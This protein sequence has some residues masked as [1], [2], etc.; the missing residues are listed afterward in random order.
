[1]T[2]QH[3]SQ[4]ILL[5][6]THGLELLYQRPLTGCRSEKL[7]STD[8]PQASGI[9]LPRT[10]PA[11]GWLIAAPPAVYAAL[12]LAGPLVVVVLYSFWTQDYL[13]IDRT[14]TLDNYRAVFV[15][16]I[17]RDL[18]FRS[19]FIA[20]S[21][22]LIIVAFCYPVAY[23][24]SFY[25]GSRKGLLLFL[26]T[27]PFWASYL[28][29]IMSWKIIL[30]NDGILNSA[31]IELGVIADPLRSLLYSKSA[32][33]LT[34]S[35]SWAAYSILPIFVSLERMDRTL[36]EAAAD[37]GDGPV[38]RFLRITLPLT[39]PGIISAIIVVMIPTVGD[40]V[41]PKLVGGKGGVMIADAIQAQF[42]RAANWPLGAALS[43]ATMA[44]VLTVALVVVGLLKM[45]VR[46][47]K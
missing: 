30:G 9:R 26:I 2:I 36:L 25:G 37:L 19:L 41:T 15:E 21:V 8:Q 28:L 10:G 42:G 17:Y 3:F 16:P 12:L 46:S 35:H 5:I 44:V 20:V 47:L 29:R 18:L 33:V 31:L 14:P 38:R 40:Y 1:M 23:Y 27:L 11:R 22:S 7:P 43:V 32:V 39:M 13:A 4:K 34:L 6:S 45:V 24:I